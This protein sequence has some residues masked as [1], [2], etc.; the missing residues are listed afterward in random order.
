MSIRLS[1]DTIN[2]HDYTKRPLAS[3]TYADMRGIVDWGNLLQFAP[4]ESGYCFLAV[5]N[6]PYMA[7]LVKDKTTASQ[8]TELQ[9]AFIKVLEQEFKGLSG[10]GD[11]TSD[12][13]EIS[14]GITSISLLGKVNQETNS[15]ITMEFTEKSGTTITKYLAEY[16]RF[17]RDPKSEAKTYG[18][19]I[20]AG[21][22]YTANLAKEVF[23]MLYIITDSTCF[24]IEKA[25][26]ILNAQ[27]TSAPFGE[28]YN[29]N[30]GDI[31]TKEI[32]VTFNAFV[33]DGKI[34]NKL[35]AIYMKTLVNS[36]TFIKG[37]INTNSYEMD[38]SISGVATDKTD[39]SV[40]NISDLA[41]KGNENGTNS[42]G[43][44]N[45]YYTFEA[46]DS[47]SEAAKDNIRIENIDPKA[48]STTT[49]NGKKYVQVDNLGTIDIGPDSTTT[50]S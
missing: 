34:A 7:T 17:V 19:F 22:S 21:N 27:P 14:D 9:N 8:F 1:T 26:L 10:I 4:F 49:I 23:N 5:I 43:S 47:N 39:V 6:G 29:M 36:G 41:I 48:D 35:A 31:S 30:K 13:M 40:A 12:T 11:I 16:L 37:K 33:V 32:S 24:N 46:L 42:D 28:L 25:F 44:T 20:D 18:G 15:Q 45:Y 38:W 50:S 2:T 3:E